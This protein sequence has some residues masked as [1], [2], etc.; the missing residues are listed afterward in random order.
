MW[1]VYVEGKGIC[2]LLCRKHNTKNE[3]NKSKV[4]SSDPAVRYRKPTLTS[5]ADSRQHLA[6]IEAEH[7]QRVS[8]FHKESVNKENVADDVLYKALMSVYWIA[9]HEIP[10]RKLVS[11]LQ[12]LEKVGV[13]EMKC[14]FGVL[15]DD[16]TDIAALEQFIT[17]IQFV[18]PDSGEVYTDFLFVENALANSKSADAQT[19]FTI[20]TAE[21]QEMKLSTEK[22]FSLVSNGA[23]VMLVARSGLAARLKE[24]NPTLISV[25][26][27][28]HKLALACVDTS[29]DLDYIA[30]V[31]QDLRT[32][33]KALEKSP[34]RTNMYL[35]LQEE[36]KSLRLQD[37]SRKIV[38]RRLKKACHTR[39]LSVGQAVD[40]VYRDLEAVFHTL[41]SLK[42]EDTLAY[43]LLKKMHKP[44]FIGCIYIFN[45][46]FPY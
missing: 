41:Q 15:C 20:L 30:E 37:Q 40:T 10:I 29:K 3:Q 44:K 19:L 43:E 39:W 34:K 8:T 13:T 6:A 14:F 21:L 42:K 12:L 45:T 4:F 18:D 9:K 28:C 36:L 32:L 1:L 2:C 5:R 27:I 7:L 33:W 31:E 46:C 25:H 16:I 38:A 35:S 23:S 26:C 11:L 17:F 22:W 24:L